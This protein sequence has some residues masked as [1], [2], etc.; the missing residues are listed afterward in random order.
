MKDSDIFAWKTFG[1]ISLACGSVLGGIVIGVKNE[2]SI[3]CTFPDLAEA[4]TL[5]RHGVLD[6]E[7]VRKA[8]NQA[9]TNFF[10]T[11]EPEK[12][13]IEIPLRADVA[14]QKPQPAPAP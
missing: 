6:Q 7:S 9:V 8:C 1:V 5:L 14:T 4:K 10:K 13:A 11:G 2:P 3:G 12:V